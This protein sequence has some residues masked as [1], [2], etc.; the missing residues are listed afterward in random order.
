MDALD[1]Y[2][3]SDRITPGER[4]ALSRMKAFVEAQPDCFQRSLVE[5]HITGSAWILNHD[6]TAALLTHHKKLNLWLQ[7]G[8]HADGD[9][10]VPQVALREAIEESGIADVVLVSNEIF[11]IDVHEIP[12]RKNEPAHLHY[13][14][15]YLVQAP[16]G[17]KEVVSD[18]SH[19]LAWVPRAKIQAYQTD[20]SVMRMARKWNAAM[21]T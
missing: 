20:E 4:P 21:R 6:A 17:A 18:E 7:P 16:K 5:G 13:D 2:A 10:D 8:G 12:A 11:D 3:A 1:R 19:A 9:P 15:R 14:V